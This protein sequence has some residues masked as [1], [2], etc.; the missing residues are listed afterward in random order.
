MSRA[1]LIETTRA[2]LTKAGYDVSSSLN[3]RS[4]CFDIVAR[5]DDSLLIIKILSNVDAFSKDNAEEMKVLADALSASPILIGERSS[6]G[7]LEPGI[8][9]S[10]FNI[11]IIS[12]ET[13]ADHTIEEVPPLIFAAPG[14]MYVKLDSDL[15]RKARETNH[16]SL[17]SLAQIAGVSRRTIQMY[18]TGMGAMIDAALRIEEF[19]NTQIIVPLNPFE[20]TPESTSEKYEV[21]GKERTDSVVLNRLI[22]IGFSIT[23]VMKSP[24]D[25]LSRVKEVLILTGTGEDEE[26][27]VQRA[28][29]TSEVSH[30][31]G[32]PSVVI[33][34]QAKNRDSIKTTAVISVD[35][36]KRIDESEELTE[37]VLSR[38]SRK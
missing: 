33:V 10:R 30:L 7:A 19:L 21:S 24:F 37:L 2:T 35:E 29:I 3:L 1:E 20:Y 26:K 34:K 4:I 14:G 13:L 22:D 31:A 12:N 9:Y 25:A 38:S 36:L 6:S 28:A 11:P 23:P 8:V 18:E 17:G 15:L 16:I 32:K 5:R 27:L